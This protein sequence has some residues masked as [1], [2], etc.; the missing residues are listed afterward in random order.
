V[1]LDSHAGQP[2]GILTDTDVSHVVA[3]G[4]NVNDIR[5]GDVMTPNPTVINAGTSIREA[6][7]LMTA[8]H[9]RHLPVVGDSGLTGI[10]DVNALFRAMLGS[11]GP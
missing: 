9:F 5:I 6:V 11:Q 8:G 3:D 2:I 10:V 4:K 1:V 7:E